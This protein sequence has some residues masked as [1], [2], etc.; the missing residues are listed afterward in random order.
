MRVA[1]QGE[2]VVQ[3]ESQANAVGE[4]SLNCHVKGDCV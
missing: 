3:I 1:I 2:G 4:A